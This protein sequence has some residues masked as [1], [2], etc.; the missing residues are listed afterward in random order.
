MRLKTRIVLLDCLLVLGIAG[1]WWLLG[2]WLDHLRDR[3][4]SSRRWI[5]PVAT[6]TISW[7]RDGRSGLRRQLE[8]LQIGAV[9]P[10][11]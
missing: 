3:H 7:D 9:D 11:V 5:I 2:R 4:K 6:I 8:Q 1:Q 10:F